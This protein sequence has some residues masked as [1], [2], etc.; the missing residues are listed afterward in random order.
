MRC[1]VPVYV[2]LADEEELSDALTRGKICFT[3][4]H[5]L[6][7]LE[8][9]VVIAVGF[10]GDYFTYFS[11]APKA[12][13]PNTLYVAAT[14]V[15]ERLYVVGE[16]EEGGK[17]PFPL[18]P[19]RSRSGACLFRRGWNACMRGKLKPPTDAIPVPGTLIGVSTS[20]SSPPNRP[21]A[22]RRRLSNRSPWSPRL[23]TPRWT[24]ACRASPAPGSSSPSPTSPAS[25]SMAK[26]QL[27]QTR[28]ERRRGRETRPSCRERAY[29]TSL[30]RR[31]LGS[32]AKMERQ[33]E[34][35]AQSSARKS[36]DSSSGRARGP[37][38]RR[39]R[40]GSADA[41]RW[42]ARRRAFAT[43]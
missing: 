24:R 19:R 1:G 22:T 13:C 26:T 14:R 17:L 15:A 23:W 27:L 18:D 34:N 43:F 20:G 16:Q 35:A 9:P 11:D 8:R 21:C 33:L 42:R 6:E 28:R 7:G 29:T 38:R 30:A 41:R 12:V 5:F 39:R 32:L 4:F 36:G 2:S 25:R 10:S 3:T 40:G 37:H 31:L